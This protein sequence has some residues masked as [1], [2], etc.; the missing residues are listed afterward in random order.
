MECRDCGVGPECRCPRRQMAP[1]YF[2]ERIAFLKEEVFDICDALARAETSL[3]RLGQGPEA[4]QLS[5]VF[6][7]VEGRLA[8]ASD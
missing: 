3:W 6:E 2:A 4:A 7:L 5:G 8:G 1:P